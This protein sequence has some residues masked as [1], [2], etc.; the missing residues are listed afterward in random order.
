MQTKIPWNPYNY[1]SIFTLIEE[2]ILANI[3]FFDKRVK[4]F[5]HSLLMLKKPCRSNN[6][7][8]NNSKSI[9]MNGDHYKRV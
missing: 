8:D 4:H 2:K 7:T 1:S 5:F 6:H 3:V 9:F